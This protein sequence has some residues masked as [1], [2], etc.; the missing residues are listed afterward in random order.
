MDKISRF[1]IKILSLSYRTN[2]KFQNKNQITN[3]DVILYS[4]KKNLFSPEYVVDVGC[5]RGEWFQK[6]NK[7]FNNSKFL[8]FDADK[9]NES[10]LLSLSNLNS[11]ISYKFSLLSNQKKLMT[12]YNMGY[13]SSVYEE[14]TSLPRFE[15][16]ILSTTLDHELTSYNIYSTNNLIKLDV[17]GSEL[18]VLDGLKD[19]IA[20]FEVIIMESSIKPYN[21]NAPLFYELYTFMNKKNYVLHDIF[22]LTRFGKEKSKLVQ[23]DCVFIRKESLLLNIKF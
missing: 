9:T 16:K 6:A 12:F 14:N 21:K 4:L 5:A 17:Q 20:L 15:E 19:K 22:D 1:L 2:H 7:I 13:G 10:K 8:L 23:F 18:D 11:N 3:T